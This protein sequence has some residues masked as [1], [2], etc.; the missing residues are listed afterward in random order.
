LNREAFFNKVTEEVSRSRRV[1]QAV[2]LVTFSLDCF[3][4]YRHRAGEA[5]ADKA[6]LAIAEILHQTSRTND[7]AADLDAGEFSI[8]LPHTHIEGATIKAEKL[9]KVV[10]RARFPRAHL[11]GDKKMSLSLGISEYPRVSK[12]A[13]SLVAS[14]EEALFFIKKQGGNQS[15]VA[16]VEENFQP[17][18]ELSSGLFGMKEKS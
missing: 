16:T 18:F 2:S 5:L 12:D 9:R 10:E 8:L 7:I 14:A 4:D 15:C 1:Q 11:L 6:L 17:D 3:S 13:E